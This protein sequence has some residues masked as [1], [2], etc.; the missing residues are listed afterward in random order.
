MSCSSKP[1]DEARHNGGSYVTV[2]CNMLLISH[3]FFFKKRTLI[4]LIFD[5]EQVGIC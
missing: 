3:T 2:M 4:D 5:V 1:A